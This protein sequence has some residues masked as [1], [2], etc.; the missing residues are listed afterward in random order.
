MEIRHFIEYGGDDTAYHACQA[1]KGVYRSEG[2]EV[3]EFTLYRE[4]EEEDLAEQAVVTAL[5]VFGL[6]KP[7]LA[8]LKITPIPSDTARKQVS[9][10]QAAHYLA[11][12][13]GID[14]G[15][16]EDDLFAAALLDSGRRA[17]LGDP[18]A[19]VH[20]SEMRRSINAVVDEASPVPDG[21]AEAE[22]S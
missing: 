8:K 5:D 2:R 6:D 1:K 20:L 11:T 7:D 12:E 14:I 3:H 22:R 16:N 10:E 21:N 18:F 4:P 19:R 17:Y 9:L 13:F 15:P